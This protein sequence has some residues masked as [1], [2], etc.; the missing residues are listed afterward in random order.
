MLAAH[1]SRVSHIGYQSREGLPK[2]VRAAGVGRGRV[3]EGRWRR[4]GPLR[5]SH[6]IPYPIL[7]PPPPFASPYTCPVFETGAV[8]GGAA[9]PPLSVTANGEEELPGNMAAAAAPGR[10]AVFAGPFILLE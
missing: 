9:G 5:P 2:W 3:G 10:A 4:R 6:T 8:A 1:F 7:P